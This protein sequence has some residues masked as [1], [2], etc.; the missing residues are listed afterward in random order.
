MSIRNMGNGTAAYTVTMPRPNQHN[1][2]NSMSM[3]QQ[4]TPQGFGQR[5]AWALQ[6]VG[7]RKSVV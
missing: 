2:D 5:S 6:P 7:D 1:L 4:P 3:P